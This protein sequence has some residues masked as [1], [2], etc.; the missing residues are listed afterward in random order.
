MTPDPHTAAE[1][2]VTGWTWTTK[3][4]ALL[5]VM[6]GGGIGA[7]WIRSRPKMR[8]LEKSAEERLR[9]DLINRVEKLERKL[10]EERTQHEAVVTL[11]RHRLNN[12]DQCIDALLMLLEAAPDR[13]PEAVSKI[14]EMRARQRTDEAI[15]KG[16]YLGAKT[17]AAGATAPPTA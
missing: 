2:T 1:V 11:L 13:V 6:V 8:E 10:D 9:D 4:V 12:S 5:N 15:E 3:L 17:A 16:A 14:K 7:A